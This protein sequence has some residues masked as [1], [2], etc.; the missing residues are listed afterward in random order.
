MN[1]HGSGLKFAFSDTEETLC[2]CMYSLNKHLLRGYYMVSTGLGAK[3]G[4]ND[5]LSF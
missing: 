4:S 5:V 2:M 3:E 1:I